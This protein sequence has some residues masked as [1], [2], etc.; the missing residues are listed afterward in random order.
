MRLRPAQVA[1]PRKV[2]PLQ[3]TTGKRPKEADDGPPWVGPLP[4]R[5]RVG[6]GKGPK[7][8]GKKCSARAPPQNQPMGSIRRKR[9]S[10]VGARRRLAPT[11]FAAA[12][13]AALSFDREFKG[14]APNPLWH[15]T[16]IPL[17]VL[18]PGITAC[19]PKPS[20]YS[21]LPTGDSGSRVP[22]SPAASLMS[23]CGMLSANGLEKPALL[24]R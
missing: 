17:L 10:T 20:A 16:T 24:R 21:P 1:S 7:P 8:S 23:I 19:C 12:T 18:C 2:I 3:A 9:E 5:P 14:T 15:H 11:T 22:C 4:Q 13:R 6:P